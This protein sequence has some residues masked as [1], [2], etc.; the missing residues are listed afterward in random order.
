MTRQEEIILKKYNSII[1]SCPYYPNC[2][3][4]CEHGELCNHIIS[5]VKSIFN[6]V[7]S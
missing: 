2:Y 4:E 3:P 5:T 6:R 1:N 7:N